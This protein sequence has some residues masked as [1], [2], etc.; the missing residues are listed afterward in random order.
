MKPLFVIKIMN[1][2]WLNLVVNRR[3]AQN[4]GDAGERAEDEGGEGRPGPQKDN[5]CKN[6]IISSLL[7]RPR[8]QKGHH[9]SH[10]NQKQIV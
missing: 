4:E 10:E 8:G 7:V 6:D 9:K 3:P 1:L 2:T 5:F